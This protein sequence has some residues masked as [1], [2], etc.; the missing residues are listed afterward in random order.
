MR[1]L[2]VPAVAVLLIGSLAACSPPDVP[3]AALAVRDGHPVAVLV[4]CDHHFARLG[5]Y[6]DDEKEQRSSQDTPL[7]T[8]DVHGKPTTDVVEVTLFGPPP[9]GWEVEESKDVTD[10][11]GRVTVRIEPLTELKP[12]VRYAISGSSFRN[13]IPVTFTTDHLGRVGPNQVLAPVDHQHMKVMSRDAFV[14]K[15]SDSCG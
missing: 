5:V 7:I 8:W 2:T 4:P 1:R 9:E 12:K 11:D 6:Q 13:G 15:A 3:I 10:T 14:R